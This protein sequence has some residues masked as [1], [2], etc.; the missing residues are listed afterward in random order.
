[1]FEELYN[2]I[3]ANTIHD[4]E[5]GCRIWQGGTDG[6]ADPYGRIKHKSHTIA[7]HIGVWKH[8]KGKIKRG[9]DIDHKCNRRLCVEKTHLQQVTKLKNQRLRAKR[10]KYRD[11]VFRCLAAK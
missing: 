4:E 9:Y 7:T 10:A 5:T 6:K 1:M 3:M 2:R 11:D 8:A